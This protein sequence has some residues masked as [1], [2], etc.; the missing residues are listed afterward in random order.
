MIPSVAASDG[1]PARAIRE[2]ERALSAR[3]HFVT[4]ATTNHGGPDGR[5]AVP[6]GTAVPQDGV[7]RWY[8][9]LSSGAYKY[10]TDLGRWLTQQVSEFDVVHAHGLFSHAPVAAWSA[11]RRAGVPYVVRPLG[12][13]A[14]YGL[15]QRRPLMKRLSLALVER[16]LLQTAAAVHFTT[17]QERAEAEELGLRVRGVV[18]P[19]GIELPETAGP[20]ALRRQ[21][22]EL[23]FL[24][25]ID[26]V[27]N[28][29]S[30][31]QAV[32]QV[33]KS[34]PAVSLRIG[35]DGPAEYVR[36][37]KRRAAQLGVGHRVTWLGHLDAAQKTA[38][39]GRASVFVQPSHSESFGIATVEALAA[40]LPCVVT[41]GVAIHSEIESSV[42]GLA[43]EATP[44]GLAEGILRLLA[45]TKLRRRM[46]HAACQLA[47]GEYS[48]EAMGERLEGLYQNL[49]KA[50]AA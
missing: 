50:L 48:L 11:A 18:I 12:V 17:S 31:L 14:R 1:G 28:L 43:T 34:R 37:L 19:L 45:D 44:A 47:R 38:E 2:I 4:T 3:G 7:T 23:L 42:A 25:R 46:S 36:E 21:T 6:L 20:S 5:A 27:K 24:S 35:G 29:D 39:F 15:E 10:S 16:R 40:G 9:G 30:L 32:A 26:P 13:L 41:R 33:A 8:F 22:D 49:A